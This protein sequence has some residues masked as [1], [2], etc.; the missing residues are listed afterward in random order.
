MWPAEAVGTAGDAAGLAG[1]QNATVTEQVDAP[2][3]VCG[4]SVQINPA[5]A[6]TAAWT[7]WQADASLL[8]GS[9]T[10]T[11]HVSVDNNPPAGRPPTITIL[12]NVEYADWPLLLTGGKALQVM[13]LQVIAGT[14]GVKR[15]P[16]DATTVVRERLSDIAL[17][18]GRFTAAH[19][20]NTRLV[21]WL[22]SLPP[23]RGCVAVAGVFPAGGGCGCTCMPSCWSCRWARWPVGCGGAARRKSSRPPVRGAHCRSSDPNTRLRTAQVT[24]GAAAAG[25]ADMPGFAVCGEY[26]TAHPEGAA[27]RRCRVGPDDAER[28][29]RGHDGRARPGKRA[30]QS[31]PTTLA[32]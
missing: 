24:L 12:A 28:L 13:R 16:G 20:E 6:E 15:W 25:P 3:N 22:G 8:L 14:C 7:Q 18:E 27:G 9:R 21:A 19:V 32:G 1:A 26:T 31:R 17:L 5:A 10:T 11:W 2:R 29:A 30:A 23:R 4:Y